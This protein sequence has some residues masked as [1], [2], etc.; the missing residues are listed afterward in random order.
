LWHKWIFLDPRLQKLPIYL[1][2]KIVIYCIPPPDGM[3]HHKRALSCGQHART[4]H[5][6]VACT[7]CRASQKMI[8]CAV[9]YICTGTLGL[10]A[11]CPCV[12]TG[13]E[14]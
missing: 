8:D 9:V 14:H 4:M 13:I 3:V 7:I 12:A 10:I 11:K 1:Y 2:Q 6:Y 5:M